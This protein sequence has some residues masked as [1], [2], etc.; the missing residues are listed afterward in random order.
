MDTRV[1]VLQPFDEFFRAN[2]S[3]VSGI[4]NKGDLSL[5]TM[6]YSPRHPFLQQALEIVVNHIQHEYRNWRQLSFNDL[7]IDPF[8]FAIRHVLSRN[9]CTLKPSSALEYR[10]VTDLKQCPK[11]NS[12]EPIGELQILKGL[13]MEGRLEIDKGLNK[14]AKIPIAAQ[15]M[16]LPRLHQSRCESQEIKVIQPK[17][18][19]LGAVAYFISEE[20]RHDFSARGG[21][22]CG[23]NMSMTFLE[24]NWRPHNR[25]PVVLMAERPWQFRETAK[26]RSFWP[27]LDIS[28]V[29]VAADYALYTEE[30]K[31]EDFEKPLSTLDFK[32]LCA[33]RF[34]GFLNVPALKDFRYILRLDDDSCITSSIKYDIFKELEARGTHYAFRAVSSDPEHVIKGLYDFAAEYITQKQ[35][36]LTHPKLFHNIKVISSTAPAPIFLSNFEIIDTTRFRKRDIA[37]FSYQIMDSKMIFHRRWGDAP[38]RLIQALI[39]IDKSSILDLCDFDYTCS[40]WIDIRSCTHKSSGDVLLRHLYP[41]VLSYRE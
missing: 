3:V 22:R 13:M 26:I 25:Y 36:N 14:L 40:T 33:F 29:C 16:F 6:A 32:L 17:P 37:D 4:Y 9:G 38:L 1:S 15:K 27:S 8:H 11:L 19:S 21:R 31:F 10:L 39:F 7:L 20:V 24:R 35:I 23:F 28:F 18:I 5:H 30:D 12:P 2:A 34:S 41:L